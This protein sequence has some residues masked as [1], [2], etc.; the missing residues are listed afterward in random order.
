MIRKYVIDDDQFLINVQNDQ[1]TY[2]DYYF[3]CKAKDIY[4]HY[5]ELFDIANEFTMILKNKS[6]FQNNYFDKLFNMMA[7]YYRFINSNN[8]YEL[9]RTEEDLKNYHYDKWPKELNY[10]CD[11]L[12]FNNDFLK[13]VIIT[14]CKEKIRPNG[15]FDFSE[16][17]HIASEKL[18]YIFSKYYKIPDS[19]IFDFEKI[20][21]E[22]KYGN[23]FEY[24]NY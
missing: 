24:L 1:I 19:I 7:Y 9:F 20:Q 21:F 10:M 12:L 23:E 17:C 8:N 4:L 13:N 22:K 14:L 3:I 5:A 11:K 15:H 18:C 16:E 6:S 2:F